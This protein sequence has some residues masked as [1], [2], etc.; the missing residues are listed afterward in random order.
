MPPFNEYGAK[1]VNGAVQVGLPDEY[2]EW[3]R[4]ETAGGV[5]YNKRGD[6]Y[7]DLERGGLFAGL[8]LYPNN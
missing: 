7:F 8:N 6:E 2:V 3:L 1:I 4:G 5:P